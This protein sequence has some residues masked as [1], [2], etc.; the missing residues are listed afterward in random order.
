MFRFVSGLIC[1]VLCVLFWFWILKFGLFA[2]VDLVFVFA[3]VVVFA[4]RFALLGYCWLE[5]IVCAYVLCL[6]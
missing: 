2:L 3:C 1:Y 6:L 5:F 4:V